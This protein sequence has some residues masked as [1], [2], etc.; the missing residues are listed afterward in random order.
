MSTVHEILCKLSLEDHHSRLLSAYGS[1]KVY[2][3]FD[4][5][6][7]TLN[8]EMAIKSK[9]VDEVSIV[10]IL[11]NHSNEQRQDI[12]F[13]YQKRATK[14]LEPALKSAWSGHLETVSLGLLKTLVGTDENSLTEIICS[15]T[16]REL[17][18]IKLIY[19]T[20]KSAEDGIVFD[21]ELI[22]QDAWD[23]YDAWV[24]RKGTDVPNRC[25]S[26]NPYDTLERIKKEVKETWKVTCN[27]A[28]IRTTVSQ[29]EVDMLKIRFKFKREGVYQKALLVPL[30]W[31]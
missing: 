9:S 17:Q 15:A 22:G 10:N 30:W 2:T 26:D 23:L 11:A 6:C 18:K 28:L 5:E 19:K 4:A 3:A 24:K 8:I 13:T 14:E 12:A 27:K 7:D 20:G 1:V 21:Y 16:K 25:K 29:I 31:S